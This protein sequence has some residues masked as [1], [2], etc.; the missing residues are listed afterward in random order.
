MSRIKWPPHRKQEELLEAAAVTVTLVVSPSRG[1]R[2]EIYRSN[3]GWECRVIPF[4]KLGKEL[5]EAAISPYAKA[6]KNNF[7]AD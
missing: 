4:L 7:E 5:D 2:D 3:D 6:I 1:W